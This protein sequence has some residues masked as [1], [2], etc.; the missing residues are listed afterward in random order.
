MKILL[1]SIPDGPLERTLQPLVPWGNNRQIPIRP[2]GI[3]RLMTWMEKKG[4][5]SDIYDINNLRP[6]DEELI[7]NFKRTKPTVVG[8]SATLSHCYPN[9]K[10]IIKILRELFPYIWIVI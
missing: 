2:V 6:S 10:R 9:I 4:Y 8:L 7:K 3:L 1:C 5:S